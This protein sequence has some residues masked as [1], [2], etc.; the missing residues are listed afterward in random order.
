MTRRVAKLYVTDDCSLCD[1]ALD[2]LIRS[3]VMSGVVLTTVDV[4][5]DDDLFTTYGD[6]IPVLAYAGN[7]M[8]WPFT[9]TDI[10]SF[11][12]QSEKRS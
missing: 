11:I 4:A 1:I 8:N 10:E 6:L 3:K 9:M 2:M 12:A 5:L 7:T